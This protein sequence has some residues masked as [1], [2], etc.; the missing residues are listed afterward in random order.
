MAHSFIARVGIDKFPIIIGED[1]FDRI[2]AFCSNYSKDNIVVIADSYF[3][4]SGNFKSSKFKLIAHF[5]HIY[6]EGGIES[7]G[8]NELKRVLDYLIKYNISKDG[9][10]IAI[11]GGVVGDLA[12]FV[13]SIYHRGIDLVHVPTSSTAMIDSSIGGKT[14][15]NYSE[16]V[17]LIGTYHNPK[18]IFMDLNFLKKGGKLDILD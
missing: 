2:I 4:S 3:K 7:K 18:A 12:A 9:L 6:I 10:I 1:L 17:N 8:L 15:L 5:K 11:G 16:K 14:G 13:S